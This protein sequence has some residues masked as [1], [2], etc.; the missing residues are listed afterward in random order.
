MT[1][2]SEKLKYH[3]HVFGD[4][5][6]KRKHGQKNNPQV[7]MTIPIKP[8]ATTVVGGSSE[9]SQMLW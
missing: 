1:K 4:N 5:Q 8:L 3:E 9:K 6:I 2:H 7:R